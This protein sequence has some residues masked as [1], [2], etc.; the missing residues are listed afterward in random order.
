M[1]DTTPMGPLRHIDAGVLNIA[2]VETGP[3]DQGNRI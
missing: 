2:Y 1:R 3:A